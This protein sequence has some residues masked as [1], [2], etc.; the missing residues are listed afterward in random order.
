[1]PLIDHI[2]VY[3]YLK[4]GC[5][6]GGSGSSRWCQGPQVNR[7]GTQLG[8]ITKTLHFDKLTLMYLNE[9]SLREKYVL[10]G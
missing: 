9:Q 3:K 6:E 4:Q 7:Q 2:N 1:M 10:L 5:Q 8:K